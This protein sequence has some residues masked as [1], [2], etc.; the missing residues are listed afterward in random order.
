M[1]KNVFLLMLFIAV[2]C[3][4][5][6]PGKPV[7]FYPPGAN[8]PSGLN[9]Y[10]AVNANLNNPVS[11]SLFLGFSF[12]ALL[13]RNIPLGLTGNFRIGSVQSSQSLP[14]GISAVYAGLAYIGVFSG[15][16][17]FP[18]EPVGF[19]LLGSVGYG[20]VNY[21]YIDTAGK[22]SYSQIDGRLMLIPEASIDFRPFQ[23]LEISLGAKFLFFLGSE[24]ELGISP[25][26]LNG[27]SPFINIKFNPFKI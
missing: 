10:I 4:S 21:N 15:Y 14:A 17:F 23:F 8:K 9:G 6:E 19:S 18:E 3:F 22:S 26:E 5:Q 11:P 27:F 24:R 7:D 16:R 2:P 20:G 12:A 1:I 25:G 13:N